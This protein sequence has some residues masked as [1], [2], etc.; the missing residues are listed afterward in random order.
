MFTM[1]AFWSR[2]GTVARALICV[3]ALGFLAACNEEPLYTNLSE[4][5]ANEMAAL[6]MRY[7]IPVSRE[8]GTGGT[9]TISVD[10][11]RFADATEIL[12]SYGY[13]KTSYTDLGQV[14]AK[15]GLVATPMQERVKLLFGLNQEMSKTISEIDGVV[16]ARVHV[17][18]PEKDPLVVEQTQPSASVVIRYDKDVRISEQVPQ[19]KMIIANSVEGLA[20]DNVSV[21][22]FPV[23]T[24][25]GSRALGPAAVAEQSKRMNPALV[26]AGLLVGL[27]TLVALTLG[28]FAAWRFI[29]FRKAA[30]P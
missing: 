19:I 3:L 7:D 21:A 16:S 12:S 2:F 8:A 22:L 1:M 20:Y 5:E 18:M 13:P 9:Y 10:P 6:L 4:R 17:T 23:D 28:G 15:E 27:A 29:Q 26:V 25:V 14:F 24:G 30:S 11:K